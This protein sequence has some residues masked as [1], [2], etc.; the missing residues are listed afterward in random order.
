MDSAAG[1][2]DDTNVRAARRVQR[3]FVDVSSFRSLPG[4]NRLKNSLLQ[5]GYHA[6]VQKAR[7]GRHPL[8]RVLV[9]S[10]P[11]RRTAEQAAIK[12]KSKHRRPAALVF[13]SR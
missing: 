10:Y 3:Y 7:H 6:S 12:L 5:A 9:G 8:Y 2:D 4:A 13:A 11:S 1:D